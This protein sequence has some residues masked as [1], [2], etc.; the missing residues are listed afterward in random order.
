MWAD[1][2][3]MGAGCVYFHAKIE[4]LKKLKRCDGKV[5]SL[6]VRL[7]LGLTKQREDQQQKQEISSEKAA[8]FPR[9]FSPGGLSLLVPA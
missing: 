9:A 2:Q 1:G 8:V 5:K 3:H 6:C 4:S 7:E